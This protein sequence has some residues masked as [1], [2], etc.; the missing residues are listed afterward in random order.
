MKAIVYEKYGSP[1]VLKHEEVAV[2]KPKDNEILIKVMAASINTADQHLML[3]KPFM[4]RMFAGVIKP[5]NKILGADISGVVISVGKQVKEFR[6]GDEIYGDLSALH[7]G[8][9]AEY[10]LATSDLISKKP[11]NLSYQEAASIPMAA[12]TAL[13]GLRDH[14][15]I[16]RAGKV[17]IN[18]ASGGVGS[19]AI[20]IAKLFGTEVTAVCSTPNVAQALTLGAD[21][22]IDYKKED[23]TKSSASYDLIFDVVGNKPLGEINKLLSSHGA[24]VSTVFSMNLMMSGILSNS[25]HGKI[26]K[27]FLAKTNHADL[28]QLKQYFEEK[29]LKPVI[30]STYPLDKVPEAM[31]YLESEHAK[32]KLVINV[33]EEIG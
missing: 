5:R 15:N 3:G 11:V 7:W 6:T 28:V 31:G 29:L 4:V 8:G 2:P 32:G 16:Y 21:H 24:Y 33:Y 22:V 14:G 12:I 27:S 17:L 23:F 30:E 19:Y 26:T 25:K 13:Q 10:A 1:R 9:F 20:Q 18:G